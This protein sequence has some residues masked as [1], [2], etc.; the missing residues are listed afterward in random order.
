[1]MLLCSHDFCS[2]LFVEAKQC[3]LLCN[4]KYRFIWSQQYFL[5][6]CIT[7][8]RFDKMIMCYKCEIFVYKVKYHELW[9]TEY[10]DISGYRSIWKLFSK[11]TRLEFMFLLWISDKNTLDD[12]NHSC[13]NRHFAYFGHSLP[14]HFHIELGISQWTHENTKVHTLLN[15]GWATG[16]GE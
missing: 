11:I 9:L 13:I 7:G 12:L 1:M 15:C 4:I 8:G 10:Y 3:V 14:Y 5:S 6:H 2:I 16:L